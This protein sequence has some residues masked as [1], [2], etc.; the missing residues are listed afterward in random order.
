[1][2]FAQLTGR[3]S[4]RDIENC[5]TAFSNKLY[6]SGI[7]QPVSKL[8]LADANEKRDWRI[9]SNPDLLKQKVLTQPETDKLN[10]SSIHLFYL[11][12]GTD[13]PKRMGDRYNDTVRFTFQ[14]GCHLRFYL[15]G[16]SLKDGEVSLKLIKLT[17]RKSM[18]H[19]YLKEIKAGGPRGEINSFDYH[20]SAIE[21]FYLV[22]RL[23]PESKGC[24]LASSY[25]ITLLK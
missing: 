1:M 3:E 23:S 6:H 2:S 10:Y 11:T 21:E 9:Y 24:A 25:Q 12:A 20:T 16:S 5:L 14:D 15:T 4:L 18:P 8:T 22:L 17:G 7:K 19:I 13:Q